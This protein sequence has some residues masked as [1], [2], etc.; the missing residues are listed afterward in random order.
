MSITLNLGA[1]DLSTAYTKDYFK[2]GTQY[3]NDAGGKFVWGVYS[4]GTANTT[5]AGGKICVPILSSTNSAIFTSDITDTDAQFQT[6][7]GYA[8]ARM[9]NKT[10]GWFG[11]GGRLKVKECSTTTGLAKGTLFR[12]VATDSTISS[13]T[14]RAISAGITLEA[15]TV[16]ATSFKYVQLFSSGRP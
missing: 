9:A 7:V 15:F 8:P 12:T 2:P 5:A 4:D 11:V 3:F 1:T 14:T 13:C 10:R 16:S 6:E